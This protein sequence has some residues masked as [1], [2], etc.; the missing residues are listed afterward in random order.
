VRKTEQKMNSIRCIMPQGV[1][2]AWN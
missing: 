1:K 2:V